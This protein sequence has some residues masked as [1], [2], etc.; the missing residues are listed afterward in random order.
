MPPPRDWTTGPAKWAA[1]LVLGSASLAGMAWSLAGRER[2]PTYGAR[3]IL[4]SPEPR[5]APS[6][7][8]NAT[9][10]PEAG[11]VE[12]EQP[13]IIEPARPRAASLT[14][15]I[16]LNTATGPELELLP[17]I[18]PALAGRIIEHRKANGPFTSIDQLDDVKGIGP[19]TLER[20]RPLVKV[21]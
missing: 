11:G 10:L 7:P 21:E 12:I 13:V 17:G 16:N 3:A 20:L 6:V 15:A 4:P 2:P 1:V 9:D 19:R 5:A 14:H 18:G 8:A